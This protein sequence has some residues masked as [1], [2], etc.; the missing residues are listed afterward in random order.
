[1]GKQRTAL[2]YWISCLT[3]KAEQYCLKEDYTY[4]IGTKLFTIEVSEEYPHDL[5]YIANILYKL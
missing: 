3:L 2:Q 5:L 1:M 4:N